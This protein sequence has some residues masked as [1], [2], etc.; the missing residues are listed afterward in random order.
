LKR[1]ILEDENPK[2]VGLCIKI[3]MSDVSMN[4]HKIESSVLGE[5]EVASVI[6]WR[7]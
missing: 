4:S 1:E 5:D 2:F 7:Y 3:G 6:V